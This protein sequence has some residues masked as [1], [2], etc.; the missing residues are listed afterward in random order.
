MSG[1]ATLSL[2]IPDP[3]AAKLRSLAAI[4]HRSLAD[5]V[6]ILTEEALKQREFPEITFYNGPTGRRARLTDGPDVWE[7]IAPYAL[8]GCEWSALEES[9]PDVNERVLR[10]AIRY[11]EQY[12][13]E[14]DAR[15][16]L[17]ERG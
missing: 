13:E 5:M 17:N 10:A 15:I 8:S 4:E 12:A 14:I 16:A 3:I 1:A 11:Y 2:R 9:F 6:R 7:I